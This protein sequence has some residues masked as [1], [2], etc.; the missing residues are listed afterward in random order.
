MIN[1]TPFVHNSHCHQMINDLGILNF[2][3]K[4]EVVMYTHEVI[5]G[6]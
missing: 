2:D 6:F 5:V 3:H 4:K 1:D